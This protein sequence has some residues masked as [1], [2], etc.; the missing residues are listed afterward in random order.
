MLDSLTDLVAYNAWANDRLRRTLEAALT[1]DIEKRR[2]FQHLLRVEPAWLA[3]LQGEPDPAGAGE[4]WDEPDAAG[5]AALVEGNRASYAAFLAGLEEAELQRPIRY[6]LPNGQLGG[7][8]VGET[9]LHVLLHSM[10]HRGD[11]QAALG[12]AGADPPDTGYMAY[13][14]EKSG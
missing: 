6:R 5:W 7:S 14:R 3:R 12:E 8:P 9:L 13:L 1:L 2:V 10:H 11:V 4:T